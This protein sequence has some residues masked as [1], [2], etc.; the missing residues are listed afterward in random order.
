MKGGGKQGGGGDAHN[1]RGQKRAEGSHDSKSVLKKHHIGPSW[2]PTVSRQHCRA[3]FHYMQPIFCLSLNPSF[4]SDCCSA[5]RHHFSSPN[6]ALHLHSKGKCASQILTP[7][8][9][10]QPANRRDLQGALNYMCMSFATERQEVALNSSGER[11]TEEET[12]KDKL[13]ST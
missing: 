1:K 13:K 3:A 5:L 7:C 9:T 12:D 6:P 2:C 11:Q 8:A 10:V 4:P